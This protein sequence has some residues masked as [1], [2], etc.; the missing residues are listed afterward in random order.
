MSEE[1]GK[2]D[3]LRPATAPHRI[4]TIHDGFKTGDA[5]AECNSEAVLLLQHLATGPILCSWGDVDG[6]DH[7]FRLYDKQPDGRERLRATVQVILS[8]PPSSE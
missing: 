6:G 3:V 1:R 8:P 4:E 2:Y 7:T 5:Y